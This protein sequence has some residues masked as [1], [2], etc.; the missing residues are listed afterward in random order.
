MQF[1]LVG[2]P[3]CG[4]S[5]IFNHVV[6]YKAVV[7][8]F[9]GATVKYTKGNIELENQKIDVV[10]LPGTYSSQTTDEAELVAINYLRNSSNNS[11][12]INVIDASVLSRSLQLTIQLASL[13]MP[14]VIALNMMDEAENK[15]I[16]IFKERLQEIFQVPVIETIGRKGTGVFE[17]FVK[18]KEI[19]EKKQIP[20]NVKFDDKTEDLISK[21]E[22]ALENSKNDL[23]WYSRFNALKLIEK[24]PLLIN[25]YKSK[26]HPND[27]QKI[28]QIISSAE[29][30]YKKPSELI[31]SSARI[32]A[33]YRIFEKTAEVK[34]HD[35]IDI[36]KRIDDLLMHPILGYIFMIAILSIMFFSI[37]KLGSFVEPIFLDSFDL[38]NNYLAEQFK[39]NQV[40]ASIL[41]GIA[42]G[43]GGGIGIVIPFLIPFFIFLSI[44]EDTGYLARIAFLVD[45]L[46]HK[47]GLHGLSII[48][49]ILGYG[50]TVPGI[51]ATR[52]LKSKRDKFITAT[53]T[54]LIPCTAKMTVIFG[55]VGFFISM[56]AAVLIYLL[57]I[58]IVGLTGKFLSKVL[59]EIS[60]GLIL[61]IPKYHMPS[62]TTVMNKTWFRLKEFIV[63]AWPLLVVG[64]IILE[65]I[66]HFNWVEGINSFIAPFTSGLLGLPAAV[67]ITLL[68]GI[69]RKELALILLFAALGTRDVLSVMTLTQ[70][71]SFTIFVTFYVPCLATIA[72]LARELNWKNALL[73]SVITAVIAVLLS[74]GL[75][76]IGITF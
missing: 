8:N 57:N 70:V 53:L 51:L 9:P 27:F 60:P 61:E 58:V 50:C 72:A 12:L 21:I 1:I 71:F 37:F 30:D 25:E 19:Y 22:S 24:D 66:T 73:I 65:L 74:V 35:K 40:V 4:K 29:K 31:S 39:D 38:L 20:K 7:A 63:V 75:R 18:A 44:L 23:R 32:E 54:T 16:K 36:R 26:I 46:M 56:K 55:L 42:S 28:E 64:S 33:A 76:L 59:P 6:G 62:Y 48:P 52:I 49:I 17:L 3:N 45:N 67:G 11:V 68:F 14:M 47:I 2:Q 34:S 13:Q 5:T 10:D 69:M 15:G 41:I 43:I